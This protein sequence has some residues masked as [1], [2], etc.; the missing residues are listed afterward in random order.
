MFNPNPSH[1]IF[2]KFFLESLLGRLHRKESTINPRNAVVAIAMLFV[3]AG[4]STTSS[5]KLTGTKEPVWE[6]RVLVTQAAIPEGIEYKEIGIV[7]AEAKSGYDRVQTLYPLI[8][9]EARKIGANA[10]V[11]TRGGRKTTM[12]S[13]AAGYTMGTAV[14]VKDPDKLKGLPGSYH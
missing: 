3:L 1:N 9:D 12:F 4:C 5:S 13:W 7:Q 11:N 14:R 6:G 8:A 10:V 2:D